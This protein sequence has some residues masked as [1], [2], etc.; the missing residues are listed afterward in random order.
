MKRT[1]LTGARLRDPGR[2]LDTRG[3]VLIV[4]DTIESVLPGDAPKAPEADEVI[5]LNGAWLVPGLLDLRCSLRE[6]GFEYKE[7][8]RSGLRAAAAGG[9]TAVCA[10]PHTDPVTDTAAVVAQ[11]T[12]KASSAEGARLL[13][14]GAATSGLNDESLAPIGELTDA[15]CVAITQGERPIASARLM[16]RLLEYCLAFEAPVMSSAFEDSLR[17]LCTEGEWSTRL[18]LPSTPAAAESIGIARDI[19]LAELTGGRLHLN[20]VS[21]AA[22]VALVRSAKARGVAVTCDT[23]AHHMLLTTAALASF[24]PNTKVWP[25]LRSESDRAAVVAGVEDGTVDAIVSDHQPH[26]SEDKAREFQL[27]ATGISA[28]ETV[29]PNVLGLVA[30][31]ALSE[32]RA[33]TALTDGPRSALALA[34]VGL[35]E[36]SAADLTALDPKITWLPGRRTLESRATNSPFVGQLLKGRATMTL[37]GGHMVW[38][39]QDSQEIAR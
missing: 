39:G 14:V 11:V 28:L 12:A 22:G 16:R 19:A 27:A 30:S 18:G 38:R 3:S 17:G 37:V 32:A 23:T 15:G 36:G 34:P 24:D 21:T 33:I 6:P 20:R 7:D 1:L 9:F 8:I 35:F 10:M 25:P 31:G 5:D 26:H 29:V 2:Q 13:P 4:G